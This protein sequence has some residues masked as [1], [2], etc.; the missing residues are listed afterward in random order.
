[1]ANFVTNIIYIKNKDAEK[2]KEFKEKIELLKST[3]SPETEN[4]YDFPVIW[5]NAGLK[6]HTDKNTGNILP[7]FDPRGTIESLCVENNCFTIVCETAWSANLSIWKGLVKKYIPDSS[8]EYEAFAY[9]DGDYYTNR[10]ELAGKYYIEFDRD[11]PPFVEWAAAP[12]EVALEALNKLYNTDLSTMEEM[13]E[14]VNDEEPD[15]YAN[16]HLWEFV[17]IDEIS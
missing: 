14:Y 7:P 8:I 2:L 11:T 3:R 4:W 17:S 10:K 1:M 16:I 15:N 9:D 12:G 13:M 6:M 5:Q